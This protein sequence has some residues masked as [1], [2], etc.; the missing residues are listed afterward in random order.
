MSTYTL[1][2]IGEEDTKQ[3]F[4]YL[5]KFEE[6]EEHFLYYRGD[7][8]SKFG[9]SAKHI[10]ESMLGKFFVVGEKGQSYFHTKMSASFEY[11]NDSESINRIIEELS[12]KC[13]EFSKDELSSDHLTRAKQIYA[14]IHNA[15]KEFC[16]MKLDEEFKS[17]KEQSYFVSVAV[18]NNNFEKANDFLPGDSG[19]IIMG[20]CSKKEPFI[21]SDTL[22]K[23]NVQTD[24]IIDE[25]QEVLIAN[26]LWPSNIIGVFVVKDGQKYFV[27]NPGLMELFHGNAT[28]KHPYIYVNQKD[29]DEYYKALNYE[30][31]ITR[32]DYYNPD[33]E[34]KVVPENVESV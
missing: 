8:F 18:G 16:E 22:K 33:S 31:Y 30:S 6:D 24:D 14:I 15:G 27:V 12:D 20:F 4:K 32:E 28:S 17:Q 34:L 21:I 3:F 23:F 9:H 25:E 11:E 13:P 26:V 2:E 29:F 7:N 19:F 1:S 10:A 5:Q